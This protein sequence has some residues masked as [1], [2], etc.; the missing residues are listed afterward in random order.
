VIVEDLATETRFRGPELL[1]E[2][3]IVSCMSVSIPGR[4][5]P[6]GVLGVHTKQ[7]RTFSRDDIHFA[8]AVANVL[9]IAVQREA[10]ERERASLLARAEAESLGALRRLINASLDLREVGQRI[11]DRVLELLTV[12]GATV[13]SLDADSGDL[14]VLAIAGNSLSAAPGEVAFRRGTGLSG[15]A[16]KMRRPGASQDVLSDPRFVY[17]S[18]MRERLSRLGDTERARG[19]SDS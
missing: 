5:R 1:R 8:Q 6:Y 4:E 9:A 2:H 17:N 19:A 14:R 15:L 7:R 11:A 3:G 10:A 16:V 12:E 18:K 13:S